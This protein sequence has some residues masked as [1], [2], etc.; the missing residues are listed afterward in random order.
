MMKYLNIILLALVGM[1]IA[2]CSDDE[3][4]TYPRPDWSAVPEDFANGNPNWTA[5]QDI[6]GNAP[7]WT[8]DFS[9][10]DATPVWSD[11]DKSIYPTSMTAVVRLTPVLEHFAADA[12]M[13]AAFIGTEC[14]GVAQ[15]VTVDGVK[16]FFIQVKAASSENGNVEF[17]YFS[18]RF[19]RI[20]KSVAADVAYVINKIYGTV[21]APAY[22]DFEQSGKYP[23]IG[24]AYASI[25]ASLLPFSIDNGDEIAAIVGTECR[26]IAH[27]D[28]NG[29]WFDLLGTTEGESF[30]FKY[31]SAANHCTYISE[32][33]FE[34]PANG[35]SVGAPDAPVAL[36]FVPDGSMTAYVTVGAPVS[37]FANPDVDAVAAFAN[38]VCIGTGEYLG[39]STYKLVM[40]GLVADGT[41]ID[42]KYYCNSLDYLFTAPANFTFAN[43]S[44]VGSDLQPST[45]ALNLT[46][47][48]PLQM[49]ACIAPKSMLEVLANGSDIMA[50]FVGNECRGVAQVK[51]NAT[52]QAIFLFTI[53]GSIDGNEQV[54]LKLYSSTTQKLYETNVTF[55]FEPG[56]EYGTEAS[57]RS[58]EF[59]Q[60]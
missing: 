15:A 34:M 36:T 38:G 3:E 43:T 50:A 51:S 42:V 12:D 47:K 32:Q 30:R 1:S 10:N 13:M 20:Y 44:V 59:V 60:K 29:L 55:A 58:I 17:R 31:Y 57:P 23:C 22:P 6:T 9:G 11:P 18:S 25:D 46:G 2:S 14:R 56:A 21:D 4:P 41:S 16:L 54:S 24:K 28:N 33:S 39:N 5:A 8:A 7:A 49:K 40:K 52:G 26:S 27:R 48:H 35:G 53:N 37:R 19:G 45:V